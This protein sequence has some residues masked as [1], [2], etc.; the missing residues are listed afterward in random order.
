MNT[1]QFV[2][3]LENVNEHIRS[4]RNFFFDRFHSRFKI[5]HLVNCHSERVFIGNIFMFVTAKETSSRKDRHRRSRLRPLL[6]KR[7]HHRF[8]LG[9]LLCKPRHHRSR[10]RPFRREF[11]HHRSRLRPLLCKPRHHRSRLWT[12]RC[13]WIFIFRKV[14]IKVSTRFKERR[15]IIK[16]F[17]LT[18]LRSVCADHR[19]RIIKE[20]PVRILQRCRNLTVFSESENRGHFGKFFLIFCSFFKMIRNVT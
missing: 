7:R 15:Y 3:P 18:G 19:I 1:D 17:F 6:C 13:K 11:R 8:R 4:R 9:P 10:L 5:R 12:S 16:R 14:L 2:F 20:R